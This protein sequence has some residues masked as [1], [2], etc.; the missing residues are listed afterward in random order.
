MRHRSLLVFLSSLWRKKVSQRNSLCQWAYISSTKDL[1]HR[2]L[3]TSG[4][5]KL[6]PLKIAGFHHIKSL[7]RRAPWIG[8]PELNNYNSRVSNNRQDKLPIKLARPDLTWSILALS[9]F[10]TFRIFDKPKNAFMNPKRALKR[11]DWMNGEVGKRSGHAYPSSD[12]SG[13][14]D[15]TSGASKLPT[16]RLASEKT[17]KVYAYSYLPIPAE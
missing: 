5:E 9:C 1:E 17:Q 2:V 11:V 10:H 4:P 3:V 13:V 12:M 15:A 8:G 14:R 16:K 6:T 7:E